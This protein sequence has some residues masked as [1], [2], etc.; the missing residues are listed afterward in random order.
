MKT[1][2]VTAAMVAVLATPALA[3]KTLVKPTQTQCAAQIEQLQS[4]ILMMKK[5]LMLS[6]SNVTLM[7]KKPVN[8][9]KKAG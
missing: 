1:M 4:Q 2:I 8:L 5:E 7:P 9:Q 3:N 6:Q